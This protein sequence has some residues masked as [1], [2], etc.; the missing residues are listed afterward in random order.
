MTLQNWLQT[1]TLEDRERFAELAG[2]TRHYICYQ[3]AAGH[4]RPSIDFALRLIEAS[5]QMYPRRR[6]RWLTLDVIY[7]TAAA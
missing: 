6:R 1:M 4:S 2:S 5:R 7:G 3:V